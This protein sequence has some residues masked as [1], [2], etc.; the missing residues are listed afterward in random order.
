MTDKGKSKRR[1]KEL[2][3]FGNRERY[4]SGS[5]ESE[6]RKTNKKKEESTKEIRRLSTLTRNRFSPNK[7]C[8]KRKISKYTE[9]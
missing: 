8:K 9:Y 2:I 7:K 5:K 1:G 6:R 3:F 4:S